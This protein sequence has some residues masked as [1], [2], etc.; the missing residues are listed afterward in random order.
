[1]A[2]LHREL[3][4]ATNIAREAGRIMRKYFEDGPPVEQKLDGSLIT[5]ADI[6]INRFVIR[7]LNRRFDDGVIGEEERT[8]DYGDG[9]RWICD[10]IDGT[11][12]FTWGLPTAMF[13][14]ALVI[15][16]APVLGVAY[17]PFLDRLYEA[18]SGNGSSCNG[19]KIEVSSRSFP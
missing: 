17:D 4:A 11:R 6:E 15:D 19:K 2:N 3:L 10:P 7:G 8:A 9:R 13:S 14:T 5:E 16:G 1:M 18:V 12:A